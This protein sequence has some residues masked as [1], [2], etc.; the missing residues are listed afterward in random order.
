MGGTPWMM[1]TNTQL[2][3]MMKYTTYKWTSINGVN[4]Y[5]FTNKTDD[6]KYIFISTPGYYLDTTHRYSGSEVY[7]WSTM[8]YSSYNT[9]YLCF[10]SANI[11]WNND[12]RYNGMSIRPVAPQRPW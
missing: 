10:N 5:K 2:D 6:S 3:E 1:F 9:W 11:Y 12:F 8:L 7:Y 4:G